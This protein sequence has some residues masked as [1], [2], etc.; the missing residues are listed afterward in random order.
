[1]NDGICDCC[2]GA[3]ETVTQCQDICDEILAEQR[4]AEA[5]A[6]HD[7]E[8]GSKK[9]QE[10]ID[11]YIV[12]YQKTLE[13]IAEKERENEEVRAESERM[14]EQVVKEKVD[15]SLARKREIV[16]L[17]STLSGKPG[18]PMGLEGLFYGLPAEKLVDF[19][20]YT[21]QV[22]GEMEGATQG[23]TCEP[24][25][26]AGVDLGVLWDDENF[27]DCTASVN[28]ITEEDV[29][30][31]VYRNA[32]GGSFW[33][34]RDVANYGSEKRRRLDDYDGDDDDYLGPEDDDDY[35]EDDEYDADRYKHRRDTQEDS[36]KLKELK[37]QI[38]SSGF[39]TPRRS[40]LAMTDEIVDR[41]DEILEKLEEP[42][43][44]DEENEE[45]AGQD[46]PDDTTPP[47][48]DPMALKMA[49]SEMKQRESSIT[50]GLKYAASSKILLSVLGDD[51]GQ[52][53]SKLQALGA[54]VLLHSNVSA[55]HVWQIADSV[56]SSDSLGD[57]QTCSSP[58]ALLCPPVTSQGG[59]YP[60]P[61]ILKAAE[62]ACQRE[63]E[64]LSANSC[65]SISD[66]DIPE[67]IPDGYYGY[68]K[69]VARAES[70]ALSIAFEKI[71]QVAMP[72]LDGLEG[73]IAN[74]K[75]LIESTARE[76]QNLENEIG[77]RDGTKFGRDGE[78]HSLKDTC[79]DVTAN[80]YVYE[81][82]VFGNAQQ[83][84]SGAASGTS[85]GRWDGLT[86]D[87][88]TGL[89]RM[90]WKDG[91]KCW[92]GPKRSAEVIVTCGAENKVLSADEPD[93][94]RYVLE[95]ESFI[96]C[97]EAYYQANLAKSS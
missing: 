91:Q 27:Q 94:C 72:S 18:G 60:P 48:G 95:M 36:E 5:K 68:H 37:F 26:K 8:V 50:N 41:M 25:R 61:A 45:E 52:L 87:A 9:R 31:L 97:D 63:V 47:M 82:C 84:E 96:A 21:C 4:A 88:E 53:E 70:D 75:T 23:R 35:V 55:E 67:N 1:M 51:D 85:L 79:H 65:S 16:A 30:D 73:D 28:D 81:V 42:D 15:F 49:R 78:L 54:L 14:I 43:K 40:F 38:L 92:N 62:E 46:K 93:T 20:T 64:S 19:I 74:K 13:Q 69:P 32:K 44:D 2:D 56:M 22:A 24:L 90:I 33:S 7:F 12:L 59:K 17:T 34:T 66:D 80:K 6:I 71:L 83:K 29:A 89:R 86:V 3:D 10:S 58:L 11:A 76:I 57:E 39:S 77:G